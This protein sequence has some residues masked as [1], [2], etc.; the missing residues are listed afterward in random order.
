MWLRPSYPWL[1]NPDIECT[2]LIEVEYS[3]W[4]RERERWRLRKPVWHAGS[5]R[6]LTPYLSAA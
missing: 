2:Y 5:M 4:L 1:P 3:T 6:I